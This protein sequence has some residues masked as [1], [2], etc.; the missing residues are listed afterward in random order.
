MRHGRDR[1]DRRN[2][3]GLVE[4]AL[5]LPV[6]LVIVMFALDFG[7]VFYASVT[8]NNASRIG[9]DYAATHPYAWDGVPTSRD[10]IEKAA[11]VARINR[12]L[13]SIPCAASVPGPPV[14]T[15]ASLAL[16]QPAKVTLTCGFS[17]ITPIVGGILGS[18]LKLSASSVFPIRTGLE[19]K[20]V[21]LP[22][23]FNQA[24]VPLVKGITPAQALIEIQS[25][26][27]VAN[28][29]ADASQKGK[30]NDV[31]SQSPS[32][33]NCIDFGL[34]VTYVYKP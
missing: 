20:E 12:E 19:D 15:G 22:P 17:L 30:P 31:K 10:D 16:G 7:R 1:A 11:Y 13:A 2:G 8:L 33:G 6:A 9:A 32:G 29:V 18:P 14:F 4:F 21:P 34:T 26:G 27:L 3:Q 28:G 23:C 24:I 5:I 25:V